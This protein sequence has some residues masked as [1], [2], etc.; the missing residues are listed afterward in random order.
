MV[1]FHFRESTNA[2]GKAQGF[3]EISDTKN[4]L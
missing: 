3:C 4:A 2:V 1:A